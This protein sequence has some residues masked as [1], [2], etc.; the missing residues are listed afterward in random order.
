IRRF[1]QL[2][3]H[4]EK[5][6]GAR[7]PELLDRL[8]AGGIVAASRFGDE[9]APLVVVVQGS[10]E[11]LLKKFVEVALEVLQQE[12]ARRDVK[13]T[14]TKGTYRDVE[15]GQL[16]IGFHYAVV[17]S[18]LVVSNK[19]EALHLALDCHADGK[20]SL[21]TVATVADA[22]KLLPADPYAWLWLGFD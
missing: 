17:G 15:T 10:D 12:L 1:N 9:K 4:F 21:A 7:W 22:K 13:A 8:A 14:V 5:Q 11:Q 6:L 19:K 2:V 16:S 20:G 3:S 18:A